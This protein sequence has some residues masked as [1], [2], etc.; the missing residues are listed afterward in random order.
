MAWGK[1]GVTP[2]LDEFADHLIAGLS[3]G[4]AAEAMGRPRPEGGQLMQKLRRKMGD[5]AR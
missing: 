3:P 1:K 2:V 4:D 5:Q